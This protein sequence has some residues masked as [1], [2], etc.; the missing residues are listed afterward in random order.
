MKALEMISHLQGLVARYGDAPVV[1]KP[2]SAHA[3]ELSN[4]EFSDSQKYWGGPKA[5]Q[6]SRGKVFLLLRR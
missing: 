3:H 6:W 4:V 1:V 2:E 5:N